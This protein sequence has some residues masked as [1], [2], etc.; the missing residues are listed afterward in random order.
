MTEQTNDQIPQ[1]FTPEDELAMASVHLSQAQWARLHIEAARESGTFEDPVALEKAARKR[2]GEE[3][4]RQLIASRLGPAVDVPRQPQFR[5][6]PKR[7]Q[8]E[9]VRRD[10]AAKGGRS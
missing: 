7:L 6:L 10:L 1:V 9:I 2:G 8:V 5:E 4:L 3:G